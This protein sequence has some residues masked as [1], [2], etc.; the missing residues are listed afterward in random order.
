MTG[1]AAPT[2]RSF[3]S[4]A[5]AACLLVAECATASLLFGALVRAPGGTHADAPFP[6]LALCA[7]P[8]LL[9][10][11]TVAR[12]VAGAARR[13]AVLM[14]PLVACWVLGACVQDAVVGAA[15]GAP[16]TPWA[17]AG[18]PARLALVALVSSGLVVARAGVL[19]RREPSVSA[20]GA[21]AITVAA[22]FALVLFIAAIHHRTPFFAALAVH[23]AVLLAVA[24][25]A[26]SVGW[27]LARERSLE[28]SAGRALAPAGSLT[29]VALAVPM[30]GVVALGALGAAIAGPLAP[31]VGHLLVALG[32]GVGSLL[33]SLL[34]LL[35]RSAPRLHVPTPKLKVPPAPVIRPVRRLPARGAAPRWLSIVVLALAAAAAGGLLALI[36]VVLSRRFR[37]RRRAAEDA[38]ALERS[39]VF[40]WR[41]L[42]DQLASLWRRRP[43]TP[44]A[45]PPIPPVPSPHAP[46]GVRGQYRRFLTALGAAG[47][48][49]RA[50]ETADELAQRLRSA[51]LAAESA[52]L[53]SLT[54]L[55]RRARYDQG[56]EPAE[57]VATASQL[58]DALT[59]ALGAPLEGVAP[60]PRDAPRAPGTGSAPAGS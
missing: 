52:P 59:A 14:L 2:S 9:A 35:G 11:A 53:E 13:G 41:H 47:L 46:A 22:L 12:R 56:A 49:R 18:A 33:A 15:P 5:P 24:V 6:L 28:R 39:S 30:A 1:R 19:G 60:H 23:G 44:T 48:G 58:V 3:P 38:A 55:Y 10:T 7:L 45:T 40:S 37:R 50:A 31:L 26:A 16:L 57:E 54:A 42:R 34:H 17:L 29:L 51:P 43:A 25:P 4:V 36:A 32:R 27:A 20:A 8:A 21:S